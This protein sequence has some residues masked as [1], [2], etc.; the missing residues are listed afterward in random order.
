MRDGQ[1]VMSSTAREIIKINT[2][3]QKQKSKP[4][5]HE[6]YKTMIYDV[7]QTCQP[8]IIADK[9]LLLYF[10]TPT[11]KKIKFRIQLRYRRSNNFGNDP[12]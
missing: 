8:V 11:N 7:V 2:I 3:L 1:E 12:S 5:Y 10:L 9:Y 4:F 6:H